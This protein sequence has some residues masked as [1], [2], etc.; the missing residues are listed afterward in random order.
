LPFLFRD[1]FF[2]SVRHDHHN[3]DIRHVHNGKRTDDGLHRAQYRERR[4]YGLFFEIP[5]SDGS[6]GNATDASG[7]RIKINLRESGSKTGSKE[8]GNKDDGDSFGY[9]HGPEVRRPAH[10]IEKF[11]KKK[12]FSRRS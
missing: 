8:R 12:D 9:K 1:R 2:P 6:G 11:G 10:S 3:P 7:D 4:V 5:S